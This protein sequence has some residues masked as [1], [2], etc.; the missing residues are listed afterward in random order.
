MTVLTPELQEAVRKAQGEPIRMEDPQNHTR[1]V[2]VREEMYERVKAL[3]EEDLP[4]EEEQLHFLREAGK[5]AGWD[6]PE[7]DIYNDMK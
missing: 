3:L 6:D 4:S 1:Y 7:M 5:A 2:L